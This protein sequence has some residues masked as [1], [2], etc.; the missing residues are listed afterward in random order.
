[1]SNLGC[2]SWQL[3]SISPILLEAAHLVQI[4]RPAFFGTKGFGIGVAHVID[5]KVTEIVV[6]QSVTHFIGELAR[7]PVMDSV[8]SRSDC[9]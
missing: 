8:F 6:T 1:M 2:Q 5:R 7:V 9:S 3:L 4:W